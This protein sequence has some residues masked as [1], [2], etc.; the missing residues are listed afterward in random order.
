MSRLL[1]SPLKH[2][3]TSLMESSETT[4]I[5]AY[6]GPFMVYYDAFLRLSVVMEIH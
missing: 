3:F 6:G 4:S 1:L 5:V 2:S